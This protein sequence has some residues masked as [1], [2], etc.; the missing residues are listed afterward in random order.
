M[1]ARDRRSRSLGMRDGSKLGGL[2]GGVRT[3]RPVG[4]GVEFPGLHVGF[5][6]AVPQLGIEL[7]IPVAKY[8]KVLRREVLDLPLNGFN[9]AHRS[10]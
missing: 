5:E 3:K 2:T 1:E 7:R 8:G 9:V 4:G 10:P 6:L